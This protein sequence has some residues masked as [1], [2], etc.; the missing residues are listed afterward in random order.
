[1]NN[2]NFLL[3]LPAELKRA[4]DAIVTTVSAPSGIVYTCDTSINAVAGVCSYLNST[5]R[6]VYAGKFTNA[7][8][9][10]YITFGATGLG[11]SLTS[12]AEISYGSF[13]TALIASQSSANDAIGVSSS[14]PA[15]NPFGSDVMAITNA[16]LR[17]LGIAPTAGVTTAGFSCTPGTAGCYDSIITISSSMLSSG[18]L[19]FRTGSITSSQY[20][21]YTVVEHE[22]DE[23]L[24]TS[25]FGFGGLSSGGYTFVAPADLFRYH[26]TGAR[27][28]VAGTNNA[29]TSSDATN[30]CFSLDGAH[31][32][33]QYNNLD[34]GQDAG[35]WAPNCVTPRVQN[36]V[37]CPGV[38]NLDIAPTAEVLVLDLVGYTL[39]RSN[40]VGIFRTTGFMTAEDVNGNIAWDG[41][42]D[43]AFVFGSAGDILIQGDWDGSGRTKL[44]IFRPSVA[45]FA[46][47]MNG[48]GVWD[49]GVD[50]FGFFGQMGDVPIVGDWTGDGKSKIGI[51]RPATQLFALDFNN[52]LAYD[53][54]TDK[55]GH[56][57]IAGDQPI[58]GD[59][60]GDGVTKIGIY[61]P[62]VSLFALDVNNNLTWDS[63]ADK[64]NVFG[65]P[66]D[67]PLV[68]DWTGDHIA[69]VGIY[70]A[71]SSLW[72]LDIN[73]NLA[74]DA[75][76]DKAGV[77][78][79]AGDSPV[80]GDWTGTGI[81]RVGVF[82]PSVGL[83]GLDV[84]GNLAWDPGTD[85]SGIFGTTG[86]TPLIGRW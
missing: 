78:G 25:S 16:N 57:G 49:P 84:N 51:Y 53:V 32:V 5:I 37:G 61:R 55:T 27:T 82:R 26:S 4:K 20:D 21:F 38:A 67:T 36:A 8:A 12:L 22:T 17:A 62:S 9:S 44:G 75:A 41:G 59:W 81:T 15:T 52:N 72:A 70:R 42:T 80:V 7:T 83:W 77:F 35:D 58:L 13:R 85:L 39:P 14:V 43:S 64:A 86:D 30:A 2:G 54:G 34:N 79:A 19:Y 46:L 60:T 3:E 10:I 76:T 31:M 24:G 50:K 69:K 73:N 48:N 65:V 74:W 23:V 47:D 71:T 1:M 18:G 63:G 11:Q 28:L 68:G 56:F 33:Q 6:G 40:R 45:M 66:G 29:C